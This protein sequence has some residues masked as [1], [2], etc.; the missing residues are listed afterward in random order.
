MAA[1]FTAVATALSSL[2]GSAVFFLAFVFGTIRDFVP[3]IIEYISGYGWVLAL[4]V[5]GVT[6]LSAY[7]SFRSVRGFLTH[8]ETYN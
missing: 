4:I 1:V 3:V 2:F 5:L 6:S 7:S 8:E